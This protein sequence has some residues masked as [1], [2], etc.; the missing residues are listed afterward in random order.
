MPLIVSEGSGATLA[1]NQLGG[2]HYQIISPVSLHPLPGGTAFIGLISAASIHGKVDV[3]SALPAGA[4][5]L[6]LASVNIGG[7]NVGIT[8]ALPTGTNFIGLATV[9]IGSGGGNDTL[10]DGAVSTIKATVLSTASGNP[11]T[12]L[13]KGKTGNSVDANASGA[14]YVEHIGALPTGANAIGKLAANSGVDIGDVDVASIA[15]GANYIGLASVNIGGT[16]P[17]LPTGANFI[18]L[19]TVVIGSGTL[20]G[21]DGAILDGAVSS[22]KATVL[23]TA[24][25]NPLTALLKGKMGNSV[26]ANASGAL[27]T[28]H[29][30]ALPTGANF[31]GLATVTIGA[32][33][34][35]DGRIQDAGGTFYASVFSTASGAALSMQLKGLTGN[36]VDAN[37][38]GAAFVQ[39]IGA[40]PAGANYIG[41]ATTTVGA[42]LPAGANYI[43]LATAVIGNTPLV[44][45]PSGAV[46]TT[47]QRTDVMV[48]DTTQLTPKFAL[49]S[50]VSGLSHT[51][52]SSVSGKK[53]RVLAYDCMA[54][55]SVTVKFQSDSVDVTGG[56]PLA[57]N[58]GKVNAFNPVGWFESSASLPLKI[59]L[60]AAIPVGGAVTYIEV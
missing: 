40:L 39:H 45:L 33:G 44:S 31:I 48:S 23:S 30:G 46:I 10:A 41:L 27:Y 28:Q 15:A 38:S 43:G 11:L 50:A 37:A 58:S 7:G 49:I 1:T 57:V 56:Y 12:A 42:A 60:G 53:I 16:L 13:L 9:V 35:G 55:G 34:A 47:G 20:T 5:Y 52:V 4:N 6:G 54:S 22:I 32:G 25:G 51:I 18:G 24:S 19:A 17:T 26:D 14:L 36:T 2:A 59:N 3:I 21:T 8:G 29:I